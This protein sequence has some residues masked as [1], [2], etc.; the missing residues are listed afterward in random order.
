MRVVPCG[1][2]LVRVSSLY[3]RYT[4][5]TKAYISVIR[6]RRVSTIDDLCFFFNISH[7]DSR[8]FHG[9][10]SVSLKTL[11]VENFSKIRFSH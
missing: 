8:F 9:R 7:E 1:L 4:R 6:I 11:V 2:V 5:R 3:T 10:K